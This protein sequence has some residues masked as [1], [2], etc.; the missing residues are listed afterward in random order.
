MKSFITT[1]FT[2]LLYITVQAQWVNTTSGTTVKLNDVYFITADTGF[3]V[4]DSLTI[5]KTVNGGNSWNSVTI[6]NVGLDATSAVEKIAFNSN[7]TVGIAIGN[8]GNSYYFLRST[9]GGNTWNKTSQISTFGINALSFYD[10]TQVLAVGDT[11]ELFYS[12][13]AG[14]SWTLS[15]FNGFNRSITDI[16]CKNGICVACLTS[17]AIYKTTSA[18]GAWN[19]IRQTDS[20]NLKSIVLVNEDTIMAVGE[21]ANNSYLL[22]SYNGGANWL[23]PLNMQVENINDIFFPTATVGFAVGGSPILSSNSQ[24]IATSTDAGFTWQQQNE[25]TLRQLNAVFFTDVLTG[26]AVG[27]TGT[28]IKTNNGGITGI[29]K[30]QKTIALKLFPNPVNDILS[31]SISE[32]KYQSGT[33]EIYNITGQQKISET[34]YFTNGTTSLNA[35]NL[36]NGFYFCRIIFDENASTVVRLIKN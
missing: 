20:L 5:R 6:D 35:Q 2:L 8:F 33:V 32:E 25:A 7:K 10:N 27:D 21:T 9:D 26:Y 15:A 30:K 19:I 11:S 18:N 12:N 24:Y 29:N 4:G 34:I 14:L 36:S 1:L 13:N 22:T 28:I 31:I 23:P 3:V 16:S 17:G